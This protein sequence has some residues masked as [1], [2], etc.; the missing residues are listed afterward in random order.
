MKHLGTVTLTTPRLILR[1]LT[2]QDA[3]AVFKNWTNDPEV[4]KYLMWSTH[5]SV[6]ETLAI[7]TDWSAKYDDNSFYLWGIVPQDLNEPIGTISIVKQDD[8]TKMVHVGYCIGRKWWGQGYMTEAVK[9]LI[10]FFFTKVGVNRF[11]SRHDPRNPGSGKVMEKAGMKL[12]GLMR[13]SDW[14]NQGVC[15]YYMRALIAKD[16][17]KDEKSGDDVDAKNVVDTYC[18]LRCQGCGFIESHG[19]NGCVDTKG[20]PF[21]GECPIA[22][23]CISK[24][25][26]HCGECP[27]IPCAMLTQYTNDP[28]HGDTLP[29]ARISQC[30]AWLNA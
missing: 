9:A 10:D 24:T 8:E 2:P 5:K 20:N 11:E 6:D 4:T 12:E 25:Y 15:H 17:F 18:G 29:G 3:P 14:N 27:A 23:C 21:H 30:L 28:E 26:G 7:L 16:Y 22:Q 13:E 1:R 19:C